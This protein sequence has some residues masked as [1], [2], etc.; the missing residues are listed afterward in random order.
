VVCRVMGITTAKTPAPPLERF[1]CAHHT[2]R[3][4]RKHGSW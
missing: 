3:A 2:I 1:L 4:N